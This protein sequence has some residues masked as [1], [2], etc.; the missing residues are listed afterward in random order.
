MF[1]FILYP[2]RAILTLTMKK[3]VLFTTLFFLCVHILLFPL[4]KQASIAATA[5]EIH[6]S[7]VYACALTHDVYLYGSEDES[8]GLF[9]IPYTYYVK[10]IVP[11]IEYSYVQYSTDTPPYKAIYGYCKSEQLHFVDF[12]PVRP[13]LYYPL[14]VDYTLEGYSDFFPQDEIFS[15]VTLTYAYYGDYTVGSSTYCYVSLDGKMGYLPKSMDISYELNTDY[16]LAPPDVPVDELPAPSPL[17]TE[18]IVLIVIA[19]VLALA[20]AYYLLRPRPSASHI[21]DEDLEEGKL[22]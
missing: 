18:Q 3:F 1:S 15:S 19:L 2:S 17:R 11:G 21:S 9:R 20:V 6:P 5:E 4:P 14:N 8:S 13:F 12:E 22:P 10:V 7:P 16:G